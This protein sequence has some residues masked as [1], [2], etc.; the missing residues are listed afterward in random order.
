MKI[1]PL[2][3]G[4]FTIDQTK[5]FIPFDIQKDNL[6]DRTRGSLLVEIQ[7]FLVITEHDIILLDTGLGFSKNGVLQLFENLALHGF[8]SHDVTKVLMSH[9]H[10]D[11]AGGLTL[12]N[13][14]DHTWHLA[15]PNAVHYIHEKELHFALYGSNVS[16]DSNKLKVLEQNEKVVLLSDEGFIDGYIQHQLTGGHSPFHQAFWIKEKNEIAFFGGDE[17]PQ[18]Q[19][20]KTKFIAKYD[21]DGKRAMEWRQLWWEKAKLEKWK[22]LFYH[23]ITTP[24]ID[25][26]QMSSE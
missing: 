12:L 25:P 7:P 24:S 19:Q 20:M 10:R 2:S 3:E 13:T 5:V 8:S 9:L 1:I 18:L 17:A 26:S 6:Q 15:F 21:H 23:D 14:Y 4:A 11:H 16:Y 22:I